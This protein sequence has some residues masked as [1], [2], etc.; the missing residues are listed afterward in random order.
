MKTFGPIA[1][2]VA[3]LLT[4]NS[5]AAAGSKSDGT[6]A[7]AKGNY[8][9]AAARAH[10]LAERGNPQAQALLGF[11]YEYGRGVPQDY[12]TAV[13]W[14]R[15]AAEQDYSTA[16]YLLGL[17]YEK[18]LGVEQSDTLAYTWLNRAAAHAPTSTKEYYTRIRNA[19]AAKLTAAQIADARLLASRLI[20]SAHR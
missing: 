4:A 18:G 13:Y 1:F 3:A 5:P 20:P 7:F 15:C 11:M 9:A 2:F 14:Y 8:Y 19:V 6:A 10:P 17:M 12:T 16:Q